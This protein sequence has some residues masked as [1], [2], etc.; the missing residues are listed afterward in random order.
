MTER[1][2][3]IATATGLMAAATA[4]ALVDVVEQRGAVHQLLKG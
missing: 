2:K 1:R 3:F 4:T